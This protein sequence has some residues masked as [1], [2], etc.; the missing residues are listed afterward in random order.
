MK[1]LDRPSFTIKDEKSFVNLFKFFQKAKQKRNFDYYAPIFLKVWK[2]AHSQVQFLIQL[3]K[4]GQIDYIN[5]SENFPKKRTANLEFNQNYKYNQLNPPV[6]QLWACLDLLEL[7]IEL[8]D[9]EFYVE[10]RQ[11][12]EYPIQKCPDILI[13][14]LTQIQPSNG[15]AMLDEIFSQLFPNYLTNHANSIQILEQI[16]KTNSELLISA[17]CELYK[18]ENKKEN[19]SL[20]L[21]RVLDITQSI[22]DSLLPLANWNDYQFSVSLGILAGKRE[23]LHFEQWIHQRIQTI[24]NPFI[25]AL[26]QYV[27]DYVIEPIKEAGQKP[28]PNAQGQ[29]SYDN[30]LEK[31]QLSLELITLICE[32]LLSIKAEQLSLKNQ[33]AFY[34]MYTS[35][36][37]Y[38]P[39]IGAQSASNPDVDASA[40]NIFTRY[41]NEQLSIQ[42]MV[43]SMKKFQSSKQQFEKEVY[44]CIITSLI[45]EF[46]F[47]DQY[48]L[49]DIGLTGTLIGTFISEQ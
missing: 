40:N 10:I 21:S 20:N 30:I 3:F 27:D 5:W 36:T 34:N 4:I 42:D 6:I 18:R 15:G 2:H 35:L 44:A 41:Y 11:L 31:A 32:N 48:P 12:F 38:F 22:Q 26:I 37:Q 49:K 23:F 13:V 39:Q 33:E 14:G 9:S 43:K 1:A 17:I 28:L 7:L 46:N 8:S 25:S 24:G 29:I 19:T 47:H 45:N 16:W